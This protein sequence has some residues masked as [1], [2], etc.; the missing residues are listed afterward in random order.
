MN[1]EKSLLVIVLLLFFGGASFVILHTDAPKLLY[2]IDGDTVKVEYQG[3]KQSLRLTGIDAP[4]SNTLRYWYAES[5]GQE[6]KDHLRQILSR[7][8]RINIKLENHKDYYGRLLGEILL[9][10]ESVN[11]AMIADW[12]AKE[13]K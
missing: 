8:G 1:A 10:N 9:E 7:P 3:K 12:Y 11:E 6:A 2:V 5:G 4:E 13:Y